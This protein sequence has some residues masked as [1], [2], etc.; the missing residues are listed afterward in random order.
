MKLRDLKVG[1]VFAMNG[2]RLEYHKYE[3]G[4]AVFRDSKGKTFTYGFDAAWVTMM[5]FGYNLMKGVE[6][7]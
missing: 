5:R 6:K 4:I 3:N 1:E 2:K 7:E